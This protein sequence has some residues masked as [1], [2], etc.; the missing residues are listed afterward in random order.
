MEPL[1]CLGAWVSVWYEILR[2]Q[3]Y[4]DSYINKTMEKSGAAANLA[5]SKNTQNIPSQKQKAWVWS[6]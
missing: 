4:A 1:S 5:I 2:A 6:L 3:T